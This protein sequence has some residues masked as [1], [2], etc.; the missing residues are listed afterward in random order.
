MRK[1]LFTF[2]LAFAVAMPAFADDTISSHSAVA[3]AGPVLFSSAAVRFLGINISSP[4]PNGQIVIFRSTESTFTQF[5]AT[6]TKV[7]CNYQAVNTNPATIDLFKITN[8]SYTYV[9]R[10]GACDA[11]IF[12]TYATPELD[13]AGRM[14][15]SGLPTHGQRGGPDLYP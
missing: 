1:F 9:N 15:Q 13:D 5:I 14:K 8:T 11:T 7:D 10:I 2:A 6:Q 12:F 4:A 3:T